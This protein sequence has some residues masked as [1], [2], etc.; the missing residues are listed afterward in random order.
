MVKLSILPRLRE[1]A[2]CHPNT[3]RNHILHIG[4][5]LKVDGRPSLEVVFGFTASLKMSEISSVL[6]HLGFARDSY[7]DHVCH[8]W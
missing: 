7:R 3:D 1:C 4:I 2:F 8:V 5:S 6:N